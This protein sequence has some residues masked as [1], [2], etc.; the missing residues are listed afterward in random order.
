MSRRARLGAMPVMAWVSM[1]HSMFPALSEYAERGPFSVKTVRTG[2]FGKPK[3]CSNSRRLLIT[4]DG[5]PSPNMPAV[6]PW[7]RSPAGRSYT[8]HRSDGV[9]VPAKLPAVLAAGATRAT[10]AAGPVDAGAGAEWVAGEVAGLAAA[11]TEAARAGAGADVGVGVGVK[12]G[13]GGTVRPAVVNRCSVSSPTTE[14][15]GRSTGTRGARSL[16]TKA[17]RPTW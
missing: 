16:A 12:D 8:P 9:S 11:G 14:A 7:P 2:T 15:T 17:T 6:W 10:A 13:R 4:G 3:C 1:Y 5:S